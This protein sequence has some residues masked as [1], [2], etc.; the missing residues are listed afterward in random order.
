MLEKKLKFLVPLRIEVMIKVI[1]V[2]YHKALRPILKFSVALMSKP[3]I[4]IPH[5]TPS[6]DE[7]SGRYLPASETPSESRFAG[8][9]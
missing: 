2:A 1:D 7:K 3:T 9:N 8:G 5:S 4:L 6:N